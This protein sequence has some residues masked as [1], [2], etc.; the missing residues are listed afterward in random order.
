MK[1]FFRCVLALSMAG[2]ASAALARN[3]RVVV[4]IQ[5]ALARNGSFKDNLGDDVALYFG[6]RQT[7]K[8]LQA[9]SVWTFTR[10]TSRLTSDDKHACEVAFISAAY[11]LQQR[12]REDGANAVIDIRSVH[13][14]TETNSETEYVCGSGNV[15]ASVIL[16]GTLVKMVK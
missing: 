15:A 16:K 5:D 13:N 8:V 3:D 2:V 1:I 10:K 9:L 6:E 11:A 7:P 4:P 12:A 14:G